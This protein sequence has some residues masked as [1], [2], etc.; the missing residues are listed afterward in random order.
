MSM[1]RHFLAILLTL[2]PSS[3]FACFAPDGSFEL[4]SNF[5]FASAFILAAT[6][7]IYPSKLSKAVKLAISIFIVVVLAPA[8]VY[9][10]NRLGCCDCGHRAL[11][12]SQITFALSFMAASFIVFIRYRSEKT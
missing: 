8:E 11:F 9:I 2:L 12:W 7:W 4:A 1:N 6:V 10:L 3:A 5:T